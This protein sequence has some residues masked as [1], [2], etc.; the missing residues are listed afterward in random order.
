MKFPLHRL[1]FAVVTIISLSVGP[2]AW[3]QPEVE[4]SDFY[5]AGDA[6]IK[7]D[8]CFQLTY[9][10]NWSSGSIWYK[11]AIDLSKSFEMELDLMLGC[12]DE[13]G[14]DGI[15]FVFHPKRVRVGYAGEGMGFA[16]LVP[17][18]GIELDTW[19]NDHLLDPTEDHIAVL[20]D[21]RVDHYSNLAG[22]VVIENVET[23]SNHKFKIKWDA[24]SQ[25]LS[26]YLDGKRRVQMEKDIVKEVFRSNPK[27]FWGIT[28]ATG[29]YNNAHKVCF[30]KLSFNIELG[31][32]FTDPNIGQFLLSGNPAIMRSISFSSGRSTILPSSFEE[33][34]LL[35]KFLKE[36][37]KL[38]IEVAGFTDSVGKA[39]SN[40][41]LS[42]KRAD[43]VASYLQKNGI[44][45]ARISATGQGESNPIASNLTEEGRKK[46]RRIVIRVYRPF[47]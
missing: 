1:L 26:I 20:Q 7:G 27:V 22:P 24:Y 44:N 9:D 32:L 31:N 35:V 34:D 37:P 25:E 12:K 38:T 6:I 10:R 42:Q 29:K 4:L 13:L 45:I 21:G 28:S 40:Q 15:V 3:T 16:G 36:N 19:E 33:L 11:D 8:E 46:N 41:Q 18:L 17:S 47:P 23:C 43:S 14:A 5:P 2:E 30:E 39:S